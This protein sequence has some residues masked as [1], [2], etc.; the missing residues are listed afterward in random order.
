DEAIYSRRNITR[1][2][3]IPY[4]VDLFLANIPVPVQQRTYELIQ[5]CSVPRER[6]KVKLWMDPNRNSDTLIIKCPPGR[7]KLYIECAIQRNGFFIMHFRHW[8]IEG[9]EVFIDLTWDASNQRVIEVT[10]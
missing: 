4:I 8:S 3:T 10:P 6:M 7:S 5:Q 9:R 1:D 2:S